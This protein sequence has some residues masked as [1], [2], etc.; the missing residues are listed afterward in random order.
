MISWFPVLKFPSNETDIGTFPGSSGG[1]VHITADELI[2]FCINSI[3][4]GQ[5]GWIHCAG[6]NFLPKAHI[7]SPMLLVS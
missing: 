4:V 7:K 6:T 3:C 5:S 1:D 2:S